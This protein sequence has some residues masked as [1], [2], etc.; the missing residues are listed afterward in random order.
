VLLAAADLV[1][2]PAGLDPAEAETVVVNG[3]T[4]WQMLHRTAHVQP[5]QTI[6]VHGVN[7]GVGTTLVQLARHAGVR[8]TVPPAPGTTRHCASS[9]S[10]RWTATTPRGSAGSPQ[11][12]STRRSTTS[13]ARA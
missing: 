4:A 1:P 2:V 3:I 8:V 9:V 12:A 5:G 13:A 6:L 10:C 11:A 7:G